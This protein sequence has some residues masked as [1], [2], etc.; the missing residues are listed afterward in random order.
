MKTFCFE[1]SSIGETWKPRKWAFFQI[2]LHL[3][4]KVFSVLCHFFWFLDIEFHILPKIEVKKRFMRFPSLV[5][6]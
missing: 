4:V 2:K 5:I 3:Q 6:G 1:I